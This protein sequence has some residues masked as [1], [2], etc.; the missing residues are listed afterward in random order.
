MAKSLLPKGSLDDF[1]MPG[2]IFTGRPNISFP[3]NSTIAR[4]ACCFDSSSTKQYEGFRPVKGS[5]DMSMRSL[6]EGGGRVSVLI[7]IER[8]VT[9]GLT[10]KGKREE[11]GEGEGGGGRGGACEGPSKNS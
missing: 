1:G 6:W 10:A 9:G 2:L 3:S 11:P 7:I 4:S 8:C 5:I